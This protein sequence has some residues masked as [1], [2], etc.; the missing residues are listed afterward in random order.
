MKQPFPFTD[1]D[2][3]IAALAERLS[4]VR[5]TE[6][7]TDHVGRILAEPLVADRDSPAADVSAM[8]GY[9][10][11]M[12][13]LQS[14]AD[15]PVSG[16]SQ[17]GAAPPAMVDGQVVRIFTGAIIPD[18]C[19]AVVKRED[20]EEL[21]ASIRFL[22][23]PIDATVPGSHIRRRGENAP[24]GSSVL[25]VG[26]EITPAVVAAL[27]NFGCTAPECYRRVKVAVLTT[28]DEVV[29]PATRQLE[30]WQLRNSNRS[31]VQAMLHQHALATVDTAEHVKDD[32]DSLQASLAAAIAVCDVVVMTG[33]VSMGDYDYVPETIEQLGA[34]IV[35]HGLPIRPGKPILGA[36]TQ[37]GKLIVGLPGNP[38]SA[39]INCHRFVLPLLRRIA[40]KQTWADKPALVT[41]DQPPQK[42]IPLHA[43]LLARTTATGA[44]ELVPAKGSGDLVALGRSDGY[45]AVPPMTTTTG[46]WP[47]FGW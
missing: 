21:D 40:G 29:D 38:V 42:A 23:A 35:F 32:R 28:G 13:D 5:D 47:M 18:G 34:E 26:T 16:I 31:A 2:T 25:D 37:D 8:D 44:A 14:D 7:A 27:A 1:P 30:P 11:R 12:S 33:G 36:A 45:V 9:A 10:I 15:V 6:H 43:M 22:P 24:I 19:E 3:A 39:T 41:L 4:V 46:P 20:T 17:A